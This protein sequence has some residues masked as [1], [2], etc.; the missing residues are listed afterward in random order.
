L[1]TTTHAL[2][3]TQSV[4]PTFH[5]RRRSR[6]VPDL[7]G[8]ALL[9]LYL[10]DIQDAIRCV[11]K[12]R[13]L[14]ADEAEELSSVV[15]LR[16]LQRNGAILR[17]FRGESSLR[18]FLVVVV[19]RILLDGWIARS[20]KWRPSADARRLGRVAVRLERLVFRDGMPLPQAA[21]MIRMSLRVT[22]SDDE[23]AF[24]LS[25][26]PSRPARQFVSD[27]C[28]A[29]RRSAEPDPLESLLERSGDA[30]SAMLSRVLATL[31][32]EDRELVT[33]RFE[34]QLSVRRI[35]QLRGLD[36]KP[37]YRRFD[38]V[39][40]QLRA[41]MEAQRPGSVRVV[42]SGTFSAPLTNR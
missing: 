17:N 11:S 3:S 14:T 20:G 41:G 34:Q 16:L 33:L 12:Q 9:A 2:P 37:L 32:A 18:T 38:R 35:A 39:L 4:G 8:P 15:Y 28:L 7:D 25:L 29:G 27:D 26:L 40:R 6:T 19:R 24:L 30:R 21:Q 36:E 13:N 23:L 42:P 1:L 31:D 10:P 22:D 5:A